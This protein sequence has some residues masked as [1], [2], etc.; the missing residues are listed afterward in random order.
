MK[1]TWP[2]GRFCVRDPTQPIFY[3]PA[4]VFCVGGNANVMFRI[5]VTQIL[6]FLDTNVLVYPTQNF[7]LG[8]LSY[9]NPQCES[10]VLRWNIGFNERSQ[11][12]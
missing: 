12:V 5:G 4:L 1:C 2:M 3:W 7:A 11:M 9:A 10:F 8:V 6:A